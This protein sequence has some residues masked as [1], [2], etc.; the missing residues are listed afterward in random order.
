MKKLASWGCDA[1]LWSYL[2]P[3]TKLA[4]LAK[5]GNEKKAREM[6]E[7]LRDSLYT[8][9]HTG[10]DSANRIHRKYVE[11]HDV[12]DPYNQMEV[13]D[14]EGILKRLAQLGVDLE[15]YGQIQEKFYLLYCARFDIESYHHKV[16]SN[17]EA[18][19][20]ATHGIDD[21]DVAT[22]QAIIDWTGLS[23]FWVRVRRMAQLA[24]PPWSHDRKMQQP[25]EM[26]QGI[27]ELLRGR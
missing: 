17:V 22:L 4:R 20:A 8:G 9:P 27:E 21:L 15:L 23:E 16:Q 7:S 1:D 12:Y 19:R 2:L 10:Y 13:M 11:K 18:F 5:E 24:A 6:I 14:V 25:I 26:M 3:K